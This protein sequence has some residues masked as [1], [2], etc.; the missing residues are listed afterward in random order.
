MKIHPAAA[1]TLGLLATTTCTCL[2]VRPHGGSFGTSGSKHATA[3]A[4]PA[5]QA[6]VQASPP[7]LP[8]HANTSLSPHAPAVEVP[9]KPDTPPAT[10]TVARAPTPR[11]RTLTLPPHR[12]LY[13]ELSRRLGDGHLAGMLAAYARTRWS[14]PA[15][16][17]RDA[18][19]TLALRPAAD[20]A[21]TRFAYLQLDHHGRQD[22][23]FRFVDAHGQVFLV[24]AKHHAY[25][26][27]DPLQPVRH[28]YISSGWGWRTQPVLGGKEFHRGIDYA[29]PAGTPV[30]A[31]MNGVVDMVGWHG[32]YGRMVEIRDPGSVVTRY[33]HL[34]A[35]A[36]G[37]HAGSHVARGQVIGYVGSTGL[38]TGPHLYYEVWK[39]GRRIDPLAHRIML[40]ATRLDHRE[41]HRFDDYM[42]R[43]RIAP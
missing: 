22:R 39:H 34:R 12:S 6:L 9:A 40:V 43:I 5:S 16:L 15:R 17:P 38:S 18:H 41:H 29:A 14:L 20:S 1:I 3:R 37:I 4:H 24:N 42:D 32:L 8:D 36:H 25:R 11:I 23:V 21:A 2:L 35:F 26:V 28:A 33:G 13:T 27:L 19:C 30:R 31:A 10:S 7:S